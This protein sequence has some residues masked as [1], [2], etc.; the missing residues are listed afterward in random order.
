MR[1]GAHPL[2]W[3][4]FDG[5][6]RPLGRSVAP[7]GSGAAPWRAPSAGYAAPMAA[8][9]DDL[10][11]FVAAA[12]LGSL[13][14]AAEALEITT[15]ALSK[16]IR[17]VEAVA[18]VPLLVRSPS[19]V[20]LTGVGRSVLPDVRRTVAQLDATVARLRTAASAL[21]PVRMAASPGI[22]ERIVPAAIAMLEPGATAPVELVVANSAIVRQMVLDGRADVGVAAA[23]H[24]EDLSHLGR[25]LAGDELV[26]VIP[27]EHE[28]AAAPAVSAA[29]LA[30][31]RLIVRDP[32]SHV[33]RVLDQGLAA[34]GH[35]VVAPLLEVGNASAAKAAIRAH[36]VP[37]VLSRH[38]VD[39]I[40]DR[41]AVRPI[42]GAT[43]QRTYWVLV[44]PG[45]APEASRVADHLFTAVE[46][47][48]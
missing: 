32:A 46:P 16:R 29:E 31:T 12:D 4:P 19:G 21:E 45:A 14:R 37:G 18:G 23:D 1:G 3:P 41:L 35:T 44:A 8:S 36:G 13:G 26:A 40:A 34:A 47:H 20:T 38:A 43:L 15:S 33:R 28:W 2:E 42:R 22:A 6:R 25:V 27:E 9:P 5:E 24:D 30:A 39:P 11:A 17:N 7:D 10:R 48:D